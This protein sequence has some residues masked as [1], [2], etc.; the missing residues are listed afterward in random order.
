MESEEPVGVFCGVGFE[1]IECGSRRVWTFEKRREN[2]PCRFRVILD[3]CRS[4]NQ[5]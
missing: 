3:V 2:E 4:S 1:R 5:R